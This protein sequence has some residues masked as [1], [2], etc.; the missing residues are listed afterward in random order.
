[1]RQNEGERGGRSTTKEKCLKCYD[2][3]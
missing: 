3:T 2:E 1:M